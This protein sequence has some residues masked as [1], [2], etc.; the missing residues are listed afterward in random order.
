MY[1]AYR[2]RHV[3]QDIQLAKGPRNDQLSEA[4]TFRVELSGK[5]FDIGVVL[6][7]VL[8]GLILSERVPLK[9]S[10]WTDI[11]MFAN[12]N[13]LLLLSLFFHLSY[14][15]RVATLIWDLEPRYPDIFSEHVDYLFRAQWIFFFSSLIGGLFTLLSAKVLGGA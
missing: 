7:G 3:P 15:R 14:K 5:L 10:R 6:L 2:S 8:W 12:S 1:A 13:V 11:L 9:L 4:I